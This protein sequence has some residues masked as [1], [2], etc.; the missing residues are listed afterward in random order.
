[1]VNTPKS[2]LITGG[3]GFLGVNLTRY[4]LNRG[5]RVIVL[6]IAPLDHKDVKDRARSIRG[7]IRNV[8]VVN[9]AME[10]IDIVVHTAAALPLY[11]PE[12]IRT[13]E[14]DGTR[15]VLQAALNHHI[16][17]VIHISSSAVYGIPDHH[18]LLETDPMQGVGPYGQAKVDAEGVVAE[19]RK[20]GLCVPVLRPKSFVGPERLG[21][22][23]MLYEWAYEGKNFPVLGSGNNLYQYLDVEDLCDAIWLAATLPCEITNDTFNIGAKEYGTPKTDFQ[24]V[25]DE[26]G[27]GKKVIPIPEGPAIFALSILQKL[28]LSPLYPWIYATVGKESFLSIEKAER[29]L[30]F[31]PKYSNQAALIRNYKWY[32]EH[33]AEFQNASGITHRAPWSQG[34]LKLAKV[35]F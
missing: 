34:A 14:V 6:D 18:P 19:F 2:F 8:Q 7:D 3:A 22:F 15:N 13:T 11:S 17:R 35:F 33:R 1:M 31:K 21:V 16:E 30:G 20:K 9:D 27:H 26:A 28:H 12:D 23:A 5:Q 4:L 10:G 32:L 29:V 25:L 24:A